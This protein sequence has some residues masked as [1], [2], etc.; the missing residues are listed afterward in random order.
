MV[1]PTARETVRRVPHGEATT[2][3]VEP[4][5][6]GAAPGRPGGSAT[7]VDATALVARELG[8]AQRLSEQSQPGVLG[9]I[10][11]FGAFVQRA[12]GLER[13]DEVSAH[14]VEAFVRSSTLRDG[15]SPSVATMR[16]RRSTLRLFFR[17]ARGLALVT[18]DPTVDVVLPSR[19]NR[20][21]RPLTDD[22]VQHCRR[23]SLHDL[24]STRLSVPWAL[25]EATARTAEIPHLTVSDLDLGNG[26]VWIHG[27]HNTEP[28]WA[29]L[30]PWGLTQ[31]ARRVSELGS[32]SRPHHNVRPE[33]VG[34]RRAPPLVFFAGTARDTHPRQPGRQRRRPA[35]VADRVGWR[36][37]AHADRTHRCRR[38]G[39]GGAQPRRRGA[40][41]QLELARPRPQPSGWLSGH[42]VSP[43]SNASKPS[44]RIAESMS[45]PS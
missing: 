1:E 43:R 40:H 19:T 33:R 24:T 8:R 25:G 5:V 41:D 36:P 42:R 26:R 27:S 28:R 34:Q 17:T 12:Y 44:W 22:E 2:R 16:L 45:S 39:A 30:T 7:L 11:R 13:L 21:A 37:D 4:E 18:G 20:A 32:A 14:H 6:T 10:G 9:L 31:V 35:G 3:L 15:A 23:A 29:T 38:P